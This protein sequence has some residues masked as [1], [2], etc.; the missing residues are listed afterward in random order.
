MVAGIWPIT[1]RG[2]R[3]ALYFTFPSAHSRFRFRRFTYGGQTPP[4]VRDGCSALLRKSETRECTATSP[5]YIFLP[6]SLHRTTIQ[7]LCY[8][9]PRRV[10]HAEMRLRRTR[11]LVRGSVVANPNPNRIEAATVRQHSFPE[12]NQAHIMRLACHI[13]HF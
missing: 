4:L 3:A 11:S 13:G 6:F 8:S 1:V 2:W 9:S 5:S 10:G 12:L 7:I